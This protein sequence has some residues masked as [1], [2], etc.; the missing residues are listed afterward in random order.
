MKWIFIV[1]IV[2]VIGVLIGTYYFTTE[3]NAVVLNERDEFINTLVGNPNPLCGDEEVTR[4][5]DGLHIVT[6]RLCED[7]IE[8][9]RVEGEWVVVTSFCGR[10]FQRNM[11]TDEEIFGNDSIR[12]GC[13]GGMS[14]VN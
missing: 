6:L 2:I 13:V 1:S 10:I 8:D 5:K 9:I 11:R 7:S 12:A 14:K 4:K 3:K